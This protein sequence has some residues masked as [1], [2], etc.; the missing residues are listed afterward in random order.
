[1]AGSSLSFENIGTKIKSKGYLGPV[2]MLAAF[3]LSSDY[4]LAA[5]K[6]G[7]ENGGALR[8]LDI[9]RRSSR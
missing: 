7:P 8:A 4:T 5:K 6:T 9:A 3:L 1:L 2:P